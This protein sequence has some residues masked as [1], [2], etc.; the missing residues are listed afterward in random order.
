[1][2]DR[3]YIR[4]ILSKGKVTRTD[5]LKIRKILAASGTLDYAKKEIY[6]FSKKAET[7]LEPSVMHS[8]YKD[9]LRDYFK[10]LLGI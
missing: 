8:K 7:L 3:L 5:L 6:L 9:L 2:K 10:E 1:M 4:R